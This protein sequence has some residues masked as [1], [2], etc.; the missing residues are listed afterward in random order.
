MGRAAKPFPPA[1][2][3]A[4]AAVLSG[5]PGV[6]EAHV[7]Q[8]FALGTMEAPAQVLVLLLEPT[9][10]RKDVLAQLDAGIVK[11]FPRGA[12]LDI[13]PIKKSDPLLATIRGTGTQLH[14][15]AGST[16]PAPAA[17][18]RPWWKFW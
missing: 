10:N 2:T 1:T 9:A 3:H 14:L 6:Q 4:L 17:T 8:C 7:P 11:I 18:P 5:I 13:W 12:T 16:E 15:G